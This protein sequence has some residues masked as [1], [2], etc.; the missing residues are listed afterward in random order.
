MPTCDPRL[1][2]VV[3]SDGL[4]VLIS[5]PPAISDIGLDPAIAGGQ[6]GWTHQMRPPARR[7]DVSRARLNGGPHK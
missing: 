7:G 1:R 3:S 4:M 2:R 6:I 5:L